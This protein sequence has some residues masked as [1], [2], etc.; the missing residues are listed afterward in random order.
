MSEKEVL[1]SK[2]DIMSDSICGVVSV[3]QSSGDVAHRW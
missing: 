1:V 2:G 3:E